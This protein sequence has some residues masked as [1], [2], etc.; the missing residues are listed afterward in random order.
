M[1]R[2]PIR[3]V[4]VVGDG[5]AGSTLAALLGRA[6]LRVAV[7]ARGRP[8]ALVVGESLVPGVIPILRTLGVEDQ[9]R[10]YSTLKPGATFVVDP[11]QSFAIDFESACSNIPGYA[12]NVPRDRFD[13]TLLTE[14]ERSGALVVRKA[15]RLE[16]DGAERVRLSPETLADAGFEEQPDLIVDASGRARVLPR[17]LELATQPGARRDTALF[18]HCEAV[19]IDRAGHVHSDRLERGWCWRIPLPDRVSVGVVAPPDVLAARGA[20][21]EQQ[22]DAALQQEPY[23]KALAPG[24]RRVAPVV[25]YSN[26]QSTTLRGTGANW[27]LVGDAFGFID[28]VFSSGLY[29]AMASAQR[30]ARAILSRRPGALDGY[31]RQHLRHL[32]NWREAIGYFYDGRFF[33]LLAMRDRTTQSRFGRIVNPYLSRRLPRVFT[34]EASDGRY[35]PWLLGVLAGAAR[36]EP[37]VESLAI[38]DR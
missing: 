20:T 6:G 34:G 8:G 11:G 29:L 35:D 3:N 26:Y 17:L 16:R 38:R 1:P 37:G 32:S 19:P 33:A 18:S 22:F 27:A 25:R 4:A 13:A 14:S 21:P 5:P 12:Y 24:A 23:L 7:F 31:A 36:R 9:V 28:P 15:A 10:S 2:E 30:L